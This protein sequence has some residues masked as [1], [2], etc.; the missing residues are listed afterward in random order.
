MVLFFYVS[1]CVSTCR[2]FIF[3]LFWS[4]TP[5]WNVPLTECHNSLPPYMATD[6]KLLPYSLYVLQYVSVFELLWWRKQLKINAKF[7]NVA[8]Y[9]STVCW[10]FS[11]FKRCIVEI[12]KNPLTERSSWTCFSSVITKSC[13]NFLWHKEVSASKAGTSTVILLL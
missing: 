6:S 13:V 9:L 8:G 10:F 1:L 5:W 2:V 12:M 3:H 7:D 4:H 11:L